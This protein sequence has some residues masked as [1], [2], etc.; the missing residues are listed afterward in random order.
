MKMID[1][2]FLIYGYEGPEYFCDREQET[3]E[4]ISALKNGCNVTLMSPR[5]Y[6]KTGLILNCFHHLQEEKSEIVCFYVDIYA[7]HT[8]SDFVQ[9]FG[10]AV[11]GKLDSPLQK[12][13]GLIGKLFRNSQITISPDLITGMPQ[14][15]LQFQPQHAVS[16]LEDI[17]SYIGQ[18]GRRCIVAFDEFQQIS[19]YSEE[20]V[21]ALLRTYVQQTHN[22]HF[23]FSGSKQHLMS[24]MF[25]SPKHPF[26][27]STEKMSLK[28]LDEEKYYQFA[29]SKLT[30]R[31]VSLPRDVFHNIYKQVDGVTWYL[32]SVM[33]RLYRLKSQ[34]VTE[35]AWHNV[36]GSIIKCEEDDYKRLMHLL[37]ANQSALLLAIAR[38]GV[39]A[40]PMSG[41]FLRT[42]N[43]KSASSVQRALQYLVNEEY[44]YH[45]DEGYIIYDRFFGL[46]LKS[47]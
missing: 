15:S 20:N 33:N 22:V 47:V 14:L 30:L 44:L 31:D 9:T 23:I 11:L 34:E 3:A 5:R 8:L 37:T 40:E 12:M 28:L 35:E 24:E 42:H 13:E 41:L 6:G 4:L 26:Y 10:K 43:L 1:N 16:T 29:A 17:F 46:W 45:S 32:Q 38:E 18:S 2:P 19:D 27:R 7:T 39:V 21:E 36:I 25:N